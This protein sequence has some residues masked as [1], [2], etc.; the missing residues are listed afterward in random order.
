MRRFLFLGLLVLA[1]CDPHRVFEKNQEFESRSWKIN[2]P[3]TFDFAIDDTTQ[4]YNVFLNVRNSLDYPYSRLFVNYELQAPTQASL[5]KRL[6]TEYL[7]EPK[8]G[9]PFGTSGLGDA[10][11]HRFPLLQRYTFHKTGT[12][13]VKVEQFMRLDTLQGMLAVGVRVETL[14]PGK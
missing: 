10:Y 4:R 14:P 9:K 6:I 13:H 7:F 8:T 3:V 5:D 12:Y 11:D 1:A 2:E